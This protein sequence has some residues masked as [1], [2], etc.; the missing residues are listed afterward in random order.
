MEIG[1][2]KF[3][4]GFAFPNGAHLFRTC[5]SK[6]EPKKKGTSEESRDDSDGDFGGG[7]QAAGEGIA[8]GKE[9]TTEE[10]AGGDEVAVIGPDEK[11]ADVRSHDA[12][13]ADGAAGRDDAGEHD[14]DREEEEDAS[15][16]DRDT[17][18]GG[19]VVVEG[20]EVEF[21]GVGEG[22]EGPGGDKGEDL[23]D[24]VE[25]GAAEVAHKPVNDAEGV[26]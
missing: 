2:W 8:D 19:E 13:E 11:T 24:G 1:L 7:A 12:D 17:T 25:I 5:L 10:E 4:R 20:E 15:A 23:E 16:F 22:E 9:E 18:G 26:V 21:A 14:G 3:L 6:E